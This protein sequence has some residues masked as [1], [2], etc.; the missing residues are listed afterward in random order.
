MELF[1]VFQTVVGCFVMGLDNSTL[2]QTVRFGLQKTC[3]CMRIWERNKGL[4]RNLFV[5]N[6][7]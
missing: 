7:L 4:M 6:V 5:G 1:A 3:I 2:G